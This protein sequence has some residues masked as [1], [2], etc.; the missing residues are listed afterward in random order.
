[1][2]SFSISLRARWADMDFNQHMRNA[3]FLGCAEQC[4]ME[5]LDANG[6]SMPQFQQQQLGPVVLED[7]LTYRREIRM[8]ERFT[9]DIAVAAAT[10]DWR[11]MQLRNRFV[12]E[13]DGELCAT[14][15]SVVLW[16]DLA[17]RSAV[18]PPDALRRLWQQLPRTEDFAAW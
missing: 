16:L 15:E 17:S 12:R 10:D 3:A 18:V 8:L 4:R 13:R 1:M 6:W 14:A 9:V 5:Y 2:S 11:R 7:R